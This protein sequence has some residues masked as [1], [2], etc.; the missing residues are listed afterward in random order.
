MDRVILHVDMDAFFAAVEQLDNP[1]L[2]GRPVIVGTPASQRGVVA[3]ASYEAR[4]FG[5]RSAMPSG[6][7]ARRCPEAVFVV[8]R[9]ARYQEISAAVFAILERFTPLVEPLSID[10]AFLDVTGS[11][12]LFG[13]GPEIAQAIRKEIRTG[14]GLT[15]SVGVA[16]NKFLAKLASDMNKPDGITVVPTSRE[17]VQAF[18]APLPVERIW[19]VGVVL[20][21]RLNQAGFATVGDLQQSTVRALEP[22]VGV[23]TAE[24]LLRLAYG[25][26]SRELQPAQDEKSISKEHTFSRDVRDAE[27]LER[28]LLG[29]V[30]E[31]GSRLRQKERYAGTVRL[32][33]RWQSFKTITRQQPLAPPC[34]DDTAL[35]A[36]ALAL[37]RSEITGPHAAVRLIGFGVCDL[38]DCPPEQ[39]SLFGDE[40]AD[41]EKR[42]RLSRS[43]DQL[44]QR[45]GPNAVGRGR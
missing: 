25:E 40:T 8:P 37:L 30:D 10:E 26:D 45:F 28:T 41:R 31:V 27:R 2:R 15:A 16:T 13:S 6:E 4:R 5:I 32:K 18:L 12:A 9:H 20:Q 24:H 7:A 44:R 22:V 17:A 34:C 19:G 35:R 1:A 23:H 29:L 43:V 33:L 21:R 42:E 36:A 11:Q 14:T 38:R 39:L 3:A